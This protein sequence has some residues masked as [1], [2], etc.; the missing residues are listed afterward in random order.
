MNTIRV[1]SANLLRR[2]TAENWTKK[3]PVLRQGEEGYETDTGRRKVGNGTGAW[4]ELSYT[5]DQ[6]FNPDSSN[7]QSGFAVAEADE[8]EKSRSD[9]TFA[10]ALKGTA[11]GSELLLN[12]ISPIIHGM[13]VR[14][15]SD[16]IS[17]LTAVRLIKKD[18]SGKIIS[19]Y[20]PNSDG[21]VEGVTSLYP[22]TVLLTDKEGVVIDCEYN[23]DINKAFAELQAAIMVIDSRNK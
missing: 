20:T 13:K 4:S 22:T 6:S 19:Q 11:S 21:T 16:S 1:K 10:S 2:D 15:S 5:V 18:G 8:I 9:N 7:A 12:D 23:R 17:D 3:N 14:V